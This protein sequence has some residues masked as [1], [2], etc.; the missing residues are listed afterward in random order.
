MPENSAKIQIDGD[1]KSYIAE[2]QRSVRATKQVADEA[3]KVGKSIEGWGGHLA[4]TLLKLHAVAKMI[5]GLAKAGN[6]AIASA[7]KASETLGGRALSRGIATARLGLNG[8]AVNDI[9]AGSSHTAAESDAFLSSLADAKRANGSAIGGDRAMRALRLHAAGVYDTSEI[10]GAAEGKR[11]GGSLDALDAGMGQRYGDIGFAGQ[12]EIGLRQRVNSINEN[13]EYSRTAPTVT[14]AFTSP[15][16]FGLVTPFM[17]LAGLM[18]DRTISAED[19]R[20]SE[21]NMARADA[22]N[23]HAAALR[24]SIANTP[25]VGGA[26]GESIKNERLL[27]NAGIPYGGGE[28]GLNGELK[29]QTRIMRDQASKPTVGPGSDHQ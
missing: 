29:E 10:M 18:P 1:A 14:G 5:E 17:R 2:A 8:N 26:A 19:A 11:G 28:S 7:G 13:T 24:A 4:T 15:M 6:D 25:L 27:G 16:T 9:L 20:I 12:K 22:E 23:P 3:G 21:A